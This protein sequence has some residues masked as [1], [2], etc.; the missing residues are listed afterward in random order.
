MHLVPC[1]RTLIIQKFQKSDANFE[2]SRCS[3]PSFF[4]SASSISSNN[5]AIKKFWFSGTMCFVNCLFCSLRWNP[6][7]PKGPNFFR[8]ELFSIFHLLFLLNYRLVFFLPKSQSE[9]FNFCWKTCWKFLDFV[10]C[11]GVLM[12]QKCQNVLLVFTYLDI[13]TYF[14]STLP[15]PFFVK[16]LMASI[17]LQ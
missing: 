2:L 13:Q 14:S 15:V 8:N 6:D 16:V 1:I 5:I 11:I 4:V 12:D 10:A 9:A 3:N 17:P 7:Y